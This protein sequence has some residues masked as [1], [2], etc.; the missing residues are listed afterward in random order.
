MSSKSPSPPRRRLPLLATAPAAAA[1]PG[2]RAD[3]ARN[4]AA[5]LAAARR[6]LATRPMR[7]IA[8]D[9]LAREASVGKGTL[10]RRFTDRTSLCLALLDE[11]ERELQER[12]LGH[13]GLPEATPV[14]ERLGVLLDALLAFALANAELLREAEA[15]DRAGL[16]DTAVY[17]WR[18]VAIVRLAERARAEGLPCPV[19]AEL[20]ADVLLV[21]FGGEPLARAQRRAGTPSVLRE[22]LF[23]LAGALFPFVV[24]P[25]TG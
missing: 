20:A 21:F 22:Q 4:R 6:L 8:M 17:R 11:N 18:R 7:D 24:A 5:I 2:E 3:A 9:D 15:S 25:P 10:Y 14:G 16:L 23:A 1:V 13:F 12:V 19:E